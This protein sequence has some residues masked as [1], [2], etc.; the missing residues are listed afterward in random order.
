MRIAINAL[1]LV[2]GRAGGLET[3]LKGLLRGLAAID[4]Q[5]EYLLFTNRDSLGLFELADNFTEIP[6]GVSATKRPLK[7]IYEQNFFPFKIRSADID[8]LFSP[9]NIGPAVTFCPSVA[10]IHDMVPYERPECFSTIER[11]ALKALFSMTIKT[12]TRLVTVS[13]HSK[14]TMIERLGVDPDKIVVVYNGVDEILLRKA[15]ARPGIACSPYILTTASDKAYKNIDSLLRALKILK[16][17]D[18]LEERLVVSG[19]LGGLEAGLI[20]LVDEL[21][22]TGSVD[23]PGF[24]SRDELIDLYHGARA[25]VFPSLFEGFGLP[26]LE[27]MACGAPVAS[28]NAA[29]LPEA[30]G[31]A[32]LLFNPN[33]PVDIARK[34]LKLLTDE[35][36]RTKL[37]NKG[38]KRA[39][40]FSWERAARETLVVLES[41][42]RR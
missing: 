26:V 25:F 1:Y 7:I 22:L 34:T 35:D 2:G 17:E 3:Y 16:E 5:N 36:L 6:C 28:S 38:R 27:A 40:E 41:V 13:G 8:V 15:P 19:R 32:G 10:V 24:V 4:K 23:F 39:A 31:D 11:T 12:S 29:S 42:A 33:D 18:G 14:N 20:S 9:G 21:G 30:V 37:I